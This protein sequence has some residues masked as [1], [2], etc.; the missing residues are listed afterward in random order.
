MADESLDT[1][2]LFRTQIIT[3]DKAFLH[4]E[5]KSKESSCTS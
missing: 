2:T 4:L 5:S 1:A 3:R